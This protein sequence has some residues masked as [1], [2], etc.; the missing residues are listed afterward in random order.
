[1]LQNL[2]ADSGIRGEGRGFGLD[3]DDGETTKRT[4]LNMSEEQLKKAQEEMRREKALKE[5]EKALAQNKLKSG[6]SS[7]GGTGKEEERTL[8]TMRK[9]H[10][11]GRYHG[12]IMGATT[13]LTYFPTI[14]IA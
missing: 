5:K 7:P 10:G 11:S 6:A 14:S 3:V 9:E 2:G 8:K 12:A 1:M 13:S 4:E